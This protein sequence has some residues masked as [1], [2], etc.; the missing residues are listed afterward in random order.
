VVANRQLDEGI[1]TAKKELLFA[2]QRSEQAEQDAERLGSFADLILGQIDWPKVGAQMKLTPML[3]RQFNSLV[4]KL[5]YEEDNTLTI[6]AT[7]PEFW[8]G[9]MG[10]E[11]ELIDKVAQSNTLEVATGGVEDF[12]RALTDAFGDVRISLEARLVLLNMLQEIFYQVLEIEDLEESVL[13]KK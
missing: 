12:W 10:L 1:A 4:R 9:L 6:E 3:R 13:P 11:R 2:E 7:L 5:D 8:E